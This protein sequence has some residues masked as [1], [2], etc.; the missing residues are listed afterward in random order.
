VPLKVVAAAERCPSELAKA[1]G[2]RTYLVCL[3]DAAGSYKR[4]V[5]LAG[6]A[7]S[8][9]LVVE[10]AKRLQRIGAQHTAQALLSAATKGRSAARLDSQDRMNILAALEDAPD[11]LEELQSVLL[12]EVERRREGL[13]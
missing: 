5:W 7:L 8:D 3:G 4:W 6:T 10:L 2:T 9:D 12:R 11:G 13:Y 1:D